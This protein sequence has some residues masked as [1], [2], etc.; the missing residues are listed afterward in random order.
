M[1]RQKIAFVCDFWN[2]AGTEMAAINW[3]NTLSLDFDVTL[4]LLEDKIDVKS[5]LNSNIKIKTNFWYS[6]YYARILCLKHWGLIKVPLVKTLRKKV[7]NH[8]FKDGE[9]DVIINF[10]DSSATYFKYLNFTKTKLIAWNHFNYGENVSF[11]HGSLQQLK[12]K[13]YNGYVNADFVVSVSLAA[14]KS[15]NEFFKSYNAN[16]NVHAIYTPQNVELIRQKANEKPDVEFKPGFNILHLARIDELQKQQLRLLKVISKLNKSHQNLNFYFIGDANKIEL[17][18]FNNLKKELNLKNVYY[19]GKKINPYPYVKKCDLFILP[20]MFEGYGLVLEEAL[21]LKRP[22][23]TTKM[24]SAEIL[25]D[26]KYGMVCENNAEGIFDALNK[27][28]SNKKTYENLKQKA[29]LF[30][31]QNEIILQSFK[32]LIK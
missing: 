4:M 8:V 20:S 9:Y 29:L 5:K 6:N 16:F 1:K 25:C 3:L 10:S 15:F 22:V 32:N 13:Y 30:E 19:L 21:I 23:L 12:E 27:I 31:N 7:W 18:K 14:Q 11:A 28:C 24:T 26:Q 17:E 2:N